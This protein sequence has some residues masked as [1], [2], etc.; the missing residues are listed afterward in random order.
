M[1][2]KKIDIVMDEMAEPRAGSRPMAP[3][4][5]NRRRQLK[6]IQRR[7]A[8]SLARKN[9]DSAAKHWNAYKALTGDT[10]E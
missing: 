4:T 6:A 7:L 1:V 10:D 3:S 2:E 9:F 8:N 5:R